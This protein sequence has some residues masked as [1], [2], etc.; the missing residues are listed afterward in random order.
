MLSSMF[1]R[2]GGNGTVIVTAAVTATIVAAAPAVAGPMADASANLA[3]KVKTALGLAKKANKTAKKAL[4]EAKKP[5][6]QGPAGGV[7]PAGPAGAAG[8]K[9]D[10]GAA[11]ARGADGANGIAGAAGPAGPAGPEGPPGNDGADG[12]D[13]LPGPPGNPWT[14]GGT[15]P[16]GET[17][18]GAWAYGPLPPFEVEEGVFVG[19]GTAAI[20]FPI[21]LE[22]PIEADNAHFQ[23]P[24][25]EAT[26][27][28]PGTPA[29]PQA[30]P[31]HLCVYAAVS[32][33]A[34]AND[35]I[36][37]ADLESAG[38]STT[39]AVMLFQGSPFDQGRGTYALTAPDAP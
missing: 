21:P 4:A 31:G 15:L 11:G 17:E 14:V 37:R 34:L 32:A 2:L 9:G 3:N 10:I 39:G 35:Q 33:A 38:V 30:A 24:G 16:A 7:G 1:R 27:S 22:Q 20:S 12:A 5:G 8:P 36:T 23:G 29:D 13:G 26:E 19:A 28:C 18:T 6:P 25:A